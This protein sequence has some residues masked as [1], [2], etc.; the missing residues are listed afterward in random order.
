MTNTFRKRYSKEKKEQ[1]LTFF[2][3]L[4]SWYQI[5]TVCFAF[6]SDLAPLYAPDQWLDLSMQHCRWFCRGWTLQEL[7]APEDMIFFDREW[8]ARGT[9]S[10]LRHEISSITGI[11]QHVL[12]NPDILSEYSVAQKMSWAAYRETSRE[13][14]MAYCLIGLFN[15]NMPMLYGEGAQKSFFRLQEEIMKETDDLTIFAWRAQGQQGSN[16]VL[17]R[18]SQETLRGILAQSAAEFKGCRHVS[19]IKSFQSTNNEFTVVNNRL[20]IS[21]NLTTL[22]DQSYVLDLEA[23]D[24]AKY[25]GW[26]EQRIGLKICKSPIGFVREEP[27]SLILTNKTQI[28]TGTRTAIHIRKNVTASEI[29]KF[30]RS[31]LGL[32]IHWGESLQLKSTTIRP[33]SLWSPK[34][35]VFMVHHG[36]PF[37]GY[38]DITFTSSSDSAVPLEHR[39]VVV[40]G[41]FGELDRES[42]VYASC[43]P[44]TINASEKTREVVQIVDRLNKI[45][46]DV[47]LDDL[48]RAVFPV[49]LEHA[50]YDDVRPWLKEVVLFDPININS[51]STVITAAV[52][53][54]EDS[55]SYFRN[56]LSNIEEYH[57]GIDLFVET[58]PQ[59]DASLMGT[60]DI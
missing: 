49:D 53:P 10:F 19:R 28:L 15:V 23:T 9:K 27:H 33:W 40:L 18:R 57:H 4:D 42:E 17:A 38:M 25:T 7:L 20:R 41:S 54:N 29:E 34:K 51:T 8:N 58:R 39:L 26:L 48:V 52:S 13:E 43:Y 31:T 60:V 47:G 2:L 46:D 1:R 14:D 24:K 56:L 22:E 35:R 50:D 5:A 55:N 30:P 36:E 21:A 59:Y 3:S 44:V 45:P 37:T 12:H 32:K 11:D 6:L 16:F